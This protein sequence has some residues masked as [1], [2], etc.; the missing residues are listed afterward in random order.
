[1]VRI[2]NIFE[3]SL[4][5]SNA[6]FTDRHFIF[7]DREFPVHPLPIVRIDNIFEAS[8][9]HLT[10]RF[11]DRHFIF[12]D[13]EFPVHPLPI[14]RIDVQSLPIV[15]TKKTS[16]IRSQNFTKRTIRMHASVLDNHLLTWMTLNLRVS[17]T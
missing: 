13:R 9:S 17:S 3:A 11:T 2:D 16:S 5:H 1:M 6:R 4:S 10:T 14:V 8:L 15:T 12:S 7:S